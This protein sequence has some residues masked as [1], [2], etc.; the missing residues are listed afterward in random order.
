MPFRLSIQI[1]S[2]GLPSGLSQSC[3]VKEM[4]RDVRPWLVLR[5]HL[6]Q[7]TVIVQC[8]KH[9]RPYHYRHILINIQLGERPKLDQLNSCAP[10]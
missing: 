6:E 9:G 5:N 2:V 1:A 7:N 4:Y 3:V 10:I 8:N